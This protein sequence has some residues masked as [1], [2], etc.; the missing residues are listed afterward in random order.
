LA[1]VT[2]AVDVD[3]AGGLIEWHAA[4]TDAARTSSMEDQQVLRWQVKNRQPDLRDF[5][6][7]NLRK[8]V[9]HL[10]PG[11]AVPS[12]WARC[13]RQMRLGSCR[14]EASAARI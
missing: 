12:L 14:Y 5:L 2:D 1:T 4:I 9:A 8:Q 10:P 3:G 6:F 11:S 13:A 7:G